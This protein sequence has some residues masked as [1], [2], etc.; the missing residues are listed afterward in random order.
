MILT[1][2]DV[3]FLLHFLRKSLGRNSERSFLT[4]RIKLL[5]RNRIWS[6]NFVCPWT[7]SCVFNVFNRVIVWVTVPD[8]CW[9]RRFFWKHSTFSRIFSYS[10]ILDFLLHFLHSRYVPFSLVHGSKSFASKPGWWLERIQRLQC[11]N[12]I[13]SWTKIFVLFFNRL[14]SFCFRLGPWNSSW[15]NGLNFGVILSRT[16]N[17]SILTLKDFHRRLVELKVVFVTVGMNIWR[18]GWNGL[19]FI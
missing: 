15:F 5:W 11:L 4:V 18:D 10:R 13:A 6:M 8:S 12:F 7:W 17:I 3:S 14:N 1:W 16:N 9:W 2:P 19:I